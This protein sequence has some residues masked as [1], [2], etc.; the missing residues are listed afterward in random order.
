MDSFIEQCIKLDLGSRI[1]ERRL[2]LALLEVKDIDGESLQEFSYLNQKEEMGIEKWLKI[3]KGRDYDGDE[4][5]LELLLEM[6]KKLERIEQKIFS[7]DSSLLTLPIQTQTLGIGH[8]FLCLAE[9][10]ESERIYYARLDLPIFP[11]KII[12]LYCQMLTPNIAKIIKMGSLHTKSY[13]HYIAECERLE[14]QKKRE[15]ER[16]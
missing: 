3:A 9:S 2:N 16:K 5:M 13:D 10:F 15:E 11:S 4:V 14:I 7:E 6:Y 8:E 12:P 1:I